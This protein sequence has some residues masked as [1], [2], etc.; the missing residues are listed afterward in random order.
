MSVT[1]RLQNVAQS[2]DKSKKYIKSAELARRL[3]LQR[4]TIEH[5]RRRKYGPAF[6]RIGQCIYYDEAIVNAWVEQNTH[7]CTAE[8][9]PHQ[10]P[11]PPRVLAAAV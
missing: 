2:L 3:G 7:T 4:N 6:L 5:W 8:Y 1:P 10:V 9:E 11:P